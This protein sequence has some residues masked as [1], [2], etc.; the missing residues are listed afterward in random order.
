MQSRHVTRGEVWAVEICMMPLPE[1]YRTQS[2][3]AAPD[4]PV[5]AECNLEDDE[6]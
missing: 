6:C 3:D 2:A 1:P 5:Q 4:P